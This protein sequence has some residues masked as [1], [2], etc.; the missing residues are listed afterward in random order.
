M[1]SE[2]WIGG[3]RDTVK[4]SCVVAIILAVGA[5]LLSLCS[6]GGASSS[7]STSTGS[8][9][10]NPN[11]TG[12]GSGTGSG[13]GTGS[14]SG[15]GG[16]IPQIQHFAIVVLENTNYADVVG[17][18]SAPYINS[19]IA[20]GGVA[21]NYYANVH[22]SIGNYFAMTTGEI[23]T[24]D[25]TFNGVVSDDNVVRE[26]VAAGKSWKV[27]AQSLPLAGYIGPDIYPYLRRHDPISYFSDVMPPS[28]LALNIVPFAQLSSDLAQSQLPNYSFIVPDALHDAHDCPGGPIVTC[29]TST[30]VAAADSF[31]SANLPQ[32]LTNPQFQPSGLL[33]IVFDESADDNTN[34]GGKVMCLIV[35]TSVKPGYVGIGTYNHY[36]L[37]NLSMTALGIKTIPGNGATATPMTEFFQ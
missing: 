28:T 29:P 22:P 24:T 8:S 9:S 11:S 32:L 35:G 5:L 12:S 20:S 14:G 16:G 33:V 25:D 23:P 7:S 21:S 17:S 13:T 27:Y 2:V 31:L 1:S 3:G 26:L 10:S 34:G 37:L 19:L 18:A 36:S 4:K 30:K 15:S 6:C